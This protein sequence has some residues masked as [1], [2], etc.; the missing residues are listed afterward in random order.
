MNTPQIILNCVGIIISSIVLIYS[1]FLIFRTETIINFY[2]R[3]NEKLSF[4]PFYE[5]RK[6]RAKKRWFYIFCKIG[7]VIGA[8]F[9]LLMLFILLHTIIAAQ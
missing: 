2:A 5:Y 9:S 6:S 7:G 8:L 4:L 3:V 1:Y